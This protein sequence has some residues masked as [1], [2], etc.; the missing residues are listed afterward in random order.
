MKPDSLFPKITSWMKSPFRPKVLSNITLKGIRSEGVPRLHDA[1][2]QVILSLFKMNIAGLLAFMLI[3][4]SF[5]AFTF[6]DPFA[7]T[8]FA[9][10]MLVVG[11]LVTWG[12]IRALKAFRVY[13]HNYAE[14]QMQMQT[15]MR[16][17]A[18]GASSSKGTGKNT[19]EKKAKK[20]ESRLLEVLKPKEH[21]G[22]DAKECIHCHKGIELLADSCHHC[23]QNQDELFAN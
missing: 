21:A 23:G 8:W 14:L 18:Q 20:G 19:P 13:R 3:V 10:F 7:P 1:Q 16:N 12:F 15:R 6:S 5:T 11:G 17:Y 2:H 4:F 22:W 9:L